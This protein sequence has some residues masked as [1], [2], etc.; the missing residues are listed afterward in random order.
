MSELYQDIFINN[1]IILPGIRKCN[2]R[3]DYIYNICKN[4]PQPF[5]LLDIGANYG[6]FSI[7]LALEFKDSM[8]VLIEKDP[9]VANTC[10]EIC[11]LNNIN[12]VIILNKEVSILE[13]ENLGRCEYFNIVLALSVVHHF[14]TDINP[15]IDTISKIGQYTI[16]EFPVKGEHACNQALVEEISVPKDFLFL[17]MC[18]SHTADLDRP[19][20][21]STNN[22]K[23]YFEHRRYEWLDKKLDSNITIDRIN[24]SIVISNDRK[25]T[26][27]EFILGIN[28]YS[29]LIF[30]GIYPIRIN[31]IQSLLSLPIDEIQDPTPW[32]FIVNNKI[33]AIDLNDKDV[34]NM[35]Q[36]KQN[37]FDIIVKYLLY[38]ISIY[39]YMLNN[40]EDWY[41]YIDKIKGVSN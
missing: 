40:I 9:V 35:S 37:S 13:L 3:Y 33:H 31:L 32:N 36:E 29:Y 17:G 1:N 21:L 5:S 7:R 15:V 27:S 38:N 30:N 19:L 41:K 8:F 28:L 16:F 24:N 10:K 18:K 23:Q 39:K 34:N 22:N 2:T 25:Q 20:Y 26:T 12:N 11:I 6:Y 14:N 4:I